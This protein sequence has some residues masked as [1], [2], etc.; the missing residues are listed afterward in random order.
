MSYMIRERSW[1]LDK[2]VPLIFVLTFFL[3][4]A[5]V[6][7]WAAQ[8][9]LRVGVLEKQTE[10]VQAGDRLAR[11]EERMDGLRKDN[12]QIRQKLDYVIERMM[13]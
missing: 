3:Q 6:I 13:K 1:R 7:I 9:D 2:R 8:L 11:I 12:E 10:P 5:M 4:A